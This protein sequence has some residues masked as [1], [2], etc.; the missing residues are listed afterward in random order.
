MNQVLT[1]ILEKENY[2]PAM[3]SS[4]SLIKLVNLDSPGAKDAPTSNAALAVWYSSSFIHAILQQRECQRKISQKI[5]QA[6][7]DHPW[8]E[9]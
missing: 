4:H 5:Q 3:H 8:E 1:L 7:P 9:R 2:I 6:E